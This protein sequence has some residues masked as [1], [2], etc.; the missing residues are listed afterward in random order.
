MQGAGNLQTS[1]PITVAFHDLDKRSININ[2]LNLRIWYPSSLFKKKE[3]TQSKKKG[4]KNL[5]QLNL[6]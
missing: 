3:K 6:D 4:I 5:V 1:K 2:H